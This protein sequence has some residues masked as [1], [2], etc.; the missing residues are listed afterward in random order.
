MNFIEATFTDFEPYKEEAAL[1]NLDFKLLSKGKFDTSFMFS[2]NEKFQVAKAK[3]NGKVQ[4]LGLCP[5]GFVT[6]SIPGT[7]NNEY[8]FLNKKTTGK[9]LLISPEHGAIDG[10]SFDGF[11]VFTIAIEKE[12]LLQTIDSLK[13]K[14][15]KSYFKG[16][17]VHVPL[18]IIFLTSF[19]EKANI[20]INSSKVESENGI[21]T[22]NKTDIFKFDDIL[23]LILNLLEG[24]KLQ[25]SKTP[26]RKRE[27]ALKKAL[28]LIND[29][30]FKDMPTVSQLCNYT[31]VSERSLQ[32]AFL[33]KFQVTPKEY[34][35]AVKLLKINNKLMVNDGN[36]IKISDIAVDLGFWHMGKFSADYKKKFGELPSTTLKR[37]LML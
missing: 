2:T 9:E 1:W 17:E 31:G 18:D 5:K 24:S 28:E 20:F 6:I 7:I 25:Q 8:I 11:E 35:L 33:E 37:S 23:L 14:N 36:N 30:N 32:Y 12:Y 19:I 13:Y 15:A 21:I 27:L 4:H 22:D 29:D 10:A 34:I 16:D 26:K 3:M